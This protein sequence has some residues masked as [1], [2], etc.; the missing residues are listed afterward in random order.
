MDAPRVVVEDEALPG[1]AALV[2][3]VAD[4]PIGPGD[5]IRSIGADVIELMRR[6]PSR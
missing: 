6:P 3:A 4:R 1:L 2:S 5:V